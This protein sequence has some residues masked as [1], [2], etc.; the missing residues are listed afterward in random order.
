[1]DGRT[2]VL[3]VSGSAVNVPFWRQ[4]AAGQQAKGIRGERPRGV[5]A[6]I[7]CASV[8]PPFLAI[9]H[10]S[11]N[12]QHNANCIVVELLYNWCNV[13]GA[14]DG[15]STDYGC[16]TLDTGHWTPDSGLWTMD[17]GHSMSIAMALVFVSIN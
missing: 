17:S 7:K 14:S 4:P 3:G 8:V 10:R 12:L 5:C 13:A 16:R 6:F 2:V 9:G 15:R 11:S 1:M